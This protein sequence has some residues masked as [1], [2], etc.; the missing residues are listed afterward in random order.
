MI[1]FKRYD[2]MSIMMTFD[3]LG[4]TLLCQALD[5]VLAHGITSIEVSF[6]KSVINLKRSSNIFITGMNIIIGEQTRLSIED[7]HLVWSI[8]SED[9]DCLRS[10]LAKCKETGSLQTPELIRVQV[11][12]NKRLDYL[13]GSMIGSFKT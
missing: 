9:L 12:K 7:A 1:E 8:E 5:D 11:P 3:Y 2:N 13:Y 6:D 10:L 4:I